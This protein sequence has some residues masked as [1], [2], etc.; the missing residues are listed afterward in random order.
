MYGRKSYGKDEEEEVI[1]S[2][3]SDV[4][5]IAVSPIDQFIVSSYIISIVF[6]HPMYTHKLV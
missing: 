6:R 2:G 4:V 1:P 3:S 5:C